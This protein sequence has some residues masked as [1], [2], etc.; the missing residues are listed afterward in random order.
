MFTGCSSIV[1]LH[2]V[3]ISALWGGYCSEIS[4][5]ECRMAFWPLFLSEKYVNRNV[6]GVRKNR[7]RNE[8]SHFRPYFRKKCQ[9]IFGAFG[10]K[11]RF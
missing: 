8:M 7:N 5:R 11:Y 4:E 6:S 1:L 9:K 2:A 10:A 3:K